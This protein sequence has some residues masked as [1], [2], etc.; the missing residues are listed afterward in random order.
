M[1]LS[2][3]LL[4]NVSS[5][6]HFQY[7]DQAYIVEGSSNEFYF[8]LVDLDKL[9]YGKDSEALPDHPLRYM[10]ATGSTIVAE[11]DSLFE[12]DQFTINATQ[13]FPQD[14]SIWKVE[15]TEEQIPKSGNFIFTLTEN[16][17]SKRV[18]VRSAITV[19]LNDVGG[20]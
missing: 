3:K 13:P 11:F 15:M 4:K 6:N 14:A 5:V 12:D 7:E 9:T 17:K 16:S 8:Q 19:E 10:P 18:V 1:R 2:A 20:C